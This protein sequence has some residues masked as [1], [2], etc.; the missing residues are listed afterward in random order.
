M[1]QTAVTMIPALIL[2]FPLASRAENWPSWRGPNSNSVVHGSEYPTKWGEEQNIAWKIKVP[3]WGTSTP[4]IWEQKI[5]VS[6]ADIEN[7]LVCLDR[8]GKQQW[9]A[10][11]G[12]AGSNKNR[13]ASAANPSPITDGQ[14]VYVYYKSGDL[15][16]VS[17]DGKTVWH[18]NLQDKYGPDLHN[19]DLG[20]SP[21][22]TK[23]LI[24]VAVMHQG[25]SYL[26]AVNKKTGEQVW[27]QSRDLGA[28]AEARDSYSTPLVLT[29]GDRETLIVL[30]AD[31][32]TAH[33]AATG[34]EIWRVGGLNPD[35]A[36][37]FRSIASPVAVDGM[38]IAPYARGKTL[39]AIRRA[40]QGD[41]TDTHVA[42]T[43]YTARDSTADVPTPV[44]YEGKVYISGDRGDVTC[45]EISSG[46]ELWVESLPRNRYVYSSSPV[47][48]GG[49]LYVSRE[50]G[51]TFI[52]EVGDKPKVV[53]ENSIRENTLATPALADG[54]IFLRTS[55][56]LICIGKK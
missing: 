24:V 46:K 43:M 26:L 27:N 32:V 35:S 36:R 12:A 25:P 38:I 5:F 15:A 8:D 42:W 44:A 49:N 14:N 18:I 45:I 28:P 11:L 9:K 7:G 22:M 30:G 54:Q 39:T 52:L 10:S 56:Y 47:I 55:D 29:E 37:N 53:A 3:G 13:K 23:D 48:A 4:A 21:V 6:F 51:R 41:V 34:E 40:G 2:L 50:D 17:V 20:T 31:F 1:R 16:C 19:W 33:E